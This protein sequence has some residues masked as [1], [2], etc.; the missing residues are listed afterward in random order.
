MSTHIDCHIYQ[1][2]KGTRLIPHCPS[3]SFPIVLLSAFDG[4]ECCS[5]S[6]SCHSSDPFLISRTPVDG[7]AN[8][9]EV[10]QPL[11]YQRTGIPVGSVSCKFDAAVSLLFFDCRTDEPARRTDSFFFFKKKRNSSSITFGSD[12]RSRRNIRPPRRRSIWN[13]LAFQPSTSDPAPRGESQEPG[14]VIGPSVPPRFLLSVISS[15]Q[16]EEERRESACGTLLASPADATQSVTQ[17]ASSGRCA[18]Q[19]AEKLFIASI[20]GRQQDQRGVL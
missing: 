1:R 17:A 19:L 5:A 14:R 11:L 15:S 12:S 7:A 13:I 9:K 6:S 16:Q 2:V 20:A 8:L 18:G 4:D 3:A 10:S